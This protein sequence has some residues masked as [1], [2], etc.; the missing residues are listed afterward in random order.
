MIK[1]NSENIPFQNTACIEMY[2]CLEYIYVNQ[3]DDPNIQNYVKVQIRD[4][5]SSKREDISK[6]R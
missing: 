1:F 5:N 2:S 3:S 4:V 6:M